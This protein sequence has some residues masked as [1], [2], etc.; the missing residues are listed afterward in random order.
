MRLKMFDFSYISEEEMKKYL[1]YL[2]KSNIPPG[3]KIILNAFKSKS[4]ND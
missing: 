4:S 1:K 3:D 2:L